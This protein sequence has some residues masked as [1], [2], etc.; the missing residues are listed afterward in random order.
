MAVP[1][2]RIARWG[3]KRNPAEQLLAFFLMLRQAIVTTAIN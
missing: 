3:L 1:R 2:G